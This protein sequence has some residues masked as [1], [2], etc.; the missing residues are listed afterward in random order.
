MTQRQSTC[1]TCKSP[2]FIPST[3]KTKQKTVDQ[4]AIKFTQFNCGDTSVAEL[5]SKMEQNYKEI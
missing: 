4:Y 1:S 3:K 2:G 5:E